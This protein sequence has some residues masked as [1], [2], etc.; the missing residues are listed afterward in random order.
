M[1]SEPLPRQFTD[2]RWRSYITKVSPA[3]NLLGLE[4]ATNGKDFQIYNEVKLEKI[5]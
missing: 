4:Q 2:M 3:I 5:S 1:E